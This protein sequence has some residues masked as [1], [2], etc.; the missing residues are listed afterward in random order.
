M[1][2]EPEPIFPK[3][4]M[5]PVP[6]MIHHNQMMKVQRQSLPSESAFA[7]W[8]SDRLHAVMP[9]HDTEC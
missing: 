3:F 1:G 9:F 6:G 7:T 5:G 4:C 2:L 8:Y